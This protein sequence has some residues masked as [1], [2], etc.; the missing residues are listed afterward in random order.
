[1]GVTLEAVATADHAALLAVMRAYHRELDAYDRRT[2]GQ[3]FDVVRYERAL[4]DDLDDREFWWILADGER[5][6]FVLVRTLPDWPDDSRMVATITDFY[7]APAHRRR[8]VGS[9]AV[10]A[11]LAAHRL[12][13]TYEMEAAVLPDN[14]PAL[15]FWQRLGFAV[16]YYQTA[17]RP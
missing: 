8:G 7:V 16:Q 13:G 6:G 1:M 15:A 4:L 9:A 2:V 3:P 12:R 14:A 11:L 10:E 5:A 17:R